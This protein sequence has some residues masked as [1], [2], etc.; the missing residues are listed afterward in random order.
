MKSSKENCWY[1]LKC[2][3]DRKESCPAYTEGRGRECWLVTGTRC[4]GENQGSYTDKINHCRQCPHY[5]KINKTGLSIRTKM[6]GGFGLVL[7]LLTAVGLLALTQLYAI[8]RSYTGLV[9]HKAAMI[10]DTKGAMI[11]CSRAA[12]DLR[13]YVL[14]G[15]QTYLDRYRQEE[16]G[17]Q[18]ALADIGQHIN[19]DAERQLLTLWQNSFGNFET[20]AKNAVSLKNHNQT[21]LLLQY[22]NASRGTV[23]DVLVKGQSLVDFEQ[24]LLNE[25]IAENNRQVQ[26]A[27]TIVLILIGLALVAGIAIA[28]YASR[29]IAGPLVRLEQAVSRIAA[30]D[31][32]GREIVVRTRDEV[33]RLAISFNQ[34]TASLKYLVRE[35]AGKAQTVSSASEQLTSTAQETAAGAGETAATMSQ[36]AASVEQVTDSVNRVATLAETATGHAD[37]GAEAVNMV[38]GQMQQITAAARNS[39]RIIASLNAKSQEVTRMVEL[40]TGIADQT[41]LLALNAAIEAARAGEHG[42]G[43]AVVAEEVRNLAEQSARAAREIQGLLGSM[44]QETGQAVEAMAAGDRVVAEGNRVVQEAGRSFEQIIALIRDLDRQIREVA[45]AAAEITTG[46]ENV[47][48]AAEEQSAAMEEVSAAAESLSG[49]AAALN[50]LAG[51]FKL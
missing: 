50:T 40:I 23:T 24:E 14:T 6:L 45:T 32:S 11:T 8:N 19:T 29:V 1:N 21:G 38:N 36:V 39:A 46:V 42:R 12:L 28:L 37:K 47:S 27:I 10:S 49:V 34:M 7:L 51:K 9:Q 15:N 20:Y 16:S 26:T 43:F 31:L 35:L 44:Q 22:I 5:Q 41:N 25:G 17:T 33:G 3:P 13:G 2:P 4:R 18:K 30:G 48:A